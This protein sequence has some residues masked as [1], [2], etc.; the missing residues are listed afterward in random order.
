M[1]PSLTIAQAILESNWGKSGLSK[2]CHNYFGM[3]WKEGC[4]CDYRE[5]AT[6]EQRPDGGIYTIRAKFRKYPSIEAGIEGYYKFLSGY[7]RY[8]NLI[9]GVDADD[10]CDLIRADGWATSLKYAERLK[11]L[12]R[13]YNLTDYDKKVLGDSPIAKRLVTVRISNLRIRKSPGTDYP[14][15]GEY[16]EKGQVNTIEVRFGKGSVKGWGSWP[17]GEGGFRW[18]IHLKPF[19]FNRLK[20]KIASYRYVKNALCMRPFCVL[21]R[22]ARHIPVCYNS[23]CKVLVQLDYNIVSCMIYGGVLNGIKEIAFGYYVDN[24]VVSW[25]MYECICCN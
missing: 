21:K 1:L 23:V 3:K 13:T 20:Y 25:I 2:E 14:W 15:E 22:T 11:K 16:C 7:K 10:A 24:G 4:G 19:L 6:K 18:I 12:M 17:M 8:H 5:Y 9:G